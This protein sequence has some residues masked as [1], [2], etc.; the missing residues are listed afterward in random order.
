MNPYLPNEEIDKLR[1]E[2]YARNRLIRNR[3]DHTFDIS[4]WVT[5]LV[6]LLPVVNAVIYGVAALFTAQVGELFK[7]VCTLVGCAATILAI[8]QKKVR[9]GI[10]MLGVVLLMVVCGGSVLIHIPILLFVLCVS[11]RWE[12][13]SQEEGFPLFDI[14]Y[15]EREQ[16]QKLQEQYAKERALQSGARVA[17]P[18]Q[19]SDM[20][21]L[22][23]AEKDTPIFSAELKGYYERNRD[24][25]EVFHPDVQPDAGSI[26]AAPVSTDMDTLEALLP[27][28]NQIPQGKEGELS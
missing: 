10:I 1:E 15:R 18:E 8:Y 2:R 6:S 7:A 24:T 21:D 14:S 9:F 27:P 22:L 25:G 3:L 11:Y 19:Q 28:L 26:S 5:I 17:S 20:H 4:M 12:Q 23:D 16:R 13:L